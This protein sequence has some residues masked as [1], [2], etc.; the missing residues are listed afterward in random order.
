MPLVA[1][2]VMVVALVGA[3]WVALAF[4]RLVRRR[5]RVDAGW[6]Q[7]DA[8]LQRRHDLV[9]SIVATVQSAADYE[10]DVLERTTAARAAAVAAGGAVADRARAEG[11]LTGALRT[12]F[13]VE[14]AYPELTA[15]AN[16]LALQAELA[17]TEER[18]AYAR[19][20][21]NAAVAEYE[22]SRTVFPSRVIAGAFG[23][24]ARPFFE[25]EIGSGVPVN[26][27]LSGRAP[28]DAPAGEPGAAE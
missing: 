4:N 23:F 16:F 8:E 28:S 10:R 24:G 7:I 6:A 5:N 20:Y 27:D 1:W 11:A 12:L 14:E 22:T 21:Y 2:V 18:I 9:P 19:G 13:A 26:V 25:L 17:T 3:G 15:N